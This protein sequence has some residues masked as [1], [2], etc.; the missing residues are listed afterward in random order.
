MDLYQL[1][2]FCAVFGA[3][4]GVSAVYLLVLDC[5]QYHRRHK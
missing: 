2:D 3:G 1:G 5:I 4:M